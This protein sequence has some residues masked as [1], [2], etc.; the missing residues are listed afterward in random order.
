VAQLPWLSDVDYP[1][2]L[3]KLKMGNGIFIPTPA[4]NANV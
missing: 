2:D 1:E 4:E 3:S